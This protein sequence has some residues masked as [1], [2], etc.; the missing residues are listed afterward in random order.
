MAMRILLVVVIVSMCARPSAA[1]LTEPGKNDQ[2][3]SFFGTYT[4][5]TGFSGAVASKGDQPMSW[6]GKRTPFATTWQLDYGSLGTK[7][8]TPTGTAPAKET[9]VSKNSGDYTLSYKYRWR[10]QIRLALEGGVE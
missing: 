6:E 4:A 5:D 9:A 2:F 3:V 1:Q 7:R 8:V 10:Q